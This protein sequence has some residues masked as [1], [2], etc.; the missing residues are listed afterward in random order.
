M[1]VALAGAGALTIE[2]HAMRA[3]MRADQLPAYW[4]HVSTDAQSA[5]AGECPVCGRVYAFVDALCE[6]CVAPL[7]ASE[8]PHMLFGKFRFEERVGHGGMGVVYRVSDLSLERTIAVKTLPGTSPEHAQ[9]LRAEAKAMAAVTHPN[10]AV[11][12]GSESWRGKPMLLCEFMTGGTLA[13]R[14]A[15]GPLALLEVLQL[16]IDLAEALHVIHAAGLLHRDIKPSNIGY[17]ATTAK[18][19]QNQQR[20]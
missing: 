19:L 4:W 10:L 9:R 8:V 3:S 2:H 11:I 15:R 12:Y 18:L 20:R 7:E 1:L 16:G 13:D 5:R 14:L 17:T 6:S